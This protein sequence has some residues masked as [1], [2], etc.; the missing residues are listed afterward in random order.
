LAT[1]FAV[2]KKNLKTTAIMRLFL[3]LGAL[4]F[5]FLGTNGI[6]QYNNETAANKYGQM[7]NTVVVKKII[8]R[9][10]GK[11]LKLKYDSK[12]Y[13]VTVPDSL[14]IH[15]KIDSTVLLLYNEADDYMKHPD[16]NAHGK[17]GLI[18]SIIFLCLVPVFIF[19]ALVKWTW[20]IKPSAD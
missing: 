9:R 16:Y 13:W 19:M 6:S 8:K 1:G 20:K 4:F 18:A 7:V 15:T 10:N 3:F 14:Y 17:S 5:L 12:Y 11:E 2:V